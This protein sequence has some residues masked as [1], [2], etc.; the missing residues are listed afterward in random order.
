[1]LFT[2]G[3]NNCLW[4]LASR[5]LVILTPVMFWPRVDL[6]TTTS[7]ARRGNLSTRSLMLASTRLLLVYCCRG[8]VAL[9]H[10]TQSPASVLA[11]L[12]SSST[13]TSGHRPNRSSSPPG[14]SVVHSKY[15]SPLYLNGI[16]HGD[17]PPVHAKHRHN[18]LK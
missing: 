14:A 1:M 15:I 11:S 7:L 5:P 2:I 18:G 13:S 4:P 3:F 12:V 8:Q 9:S 10:F 16:R 6:P 17:P